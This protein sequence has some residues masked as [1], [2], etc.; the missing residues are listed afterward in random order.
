M[1]YNPCKITSIL[2]PYLVLKIIIK[3]KKYHFLITGIPMSITTVAYHHNLINNVKKYDIV[4]SLLAYL[5]HILYYS[6]YSKKNSKFKFILPGTL[7][8]V[9]KVFEHL[10][11]DKTSYYLHALSHLAVIPCVYFNVKN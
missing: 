8:L 4:I 6:F 10:K 9:D 1:L 5:H 7:Y 2:V 11:Y 3:N